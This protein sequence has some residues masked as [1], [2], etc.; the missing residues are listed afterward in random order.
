MKP[1][2]F[3]ER[4]NEVEVSE[5]RIVKRI[6]TFGFISEVLQAFNVERGVV[7]TV[8]RLLLDPGGLA[9]SYLT[10]QRY[11]IIPPF[12]ILL[13]STALIV[14]L[15]PYSQSFLE[16]KEGFYQGVNS[17][18]LETQMSLLIAQYSN[19]WLWL[20]IPIVAFCSWLVNRKSGYNYAENL[21]LHTFLYGLTNILSLFVLLDFLV[22]SNFIF[23]IIFL[24]L[25]AYYTYAY[26]VFFRKLWIVSFVQNLFIYIISSVIYGAIAG[27]VLGF[28]SA[29]KADLV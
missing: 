5:S 16:F 6:T 8:K 21:V 13:V 29:Y 24:L 20:F 3:F 25:F 19:I 12:R 7:Y 27:L 26:R 2:E 15:L 11:K 10:E 22:S 18:E 1:N 17:K 9:M 28:L 14:I 4:S 23:G